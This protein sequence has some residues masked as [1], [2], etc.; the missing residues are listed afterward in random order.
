MP[1]AALCGAAATP[2]GVRCPA[3]FC[4]RRDFARMLHRNIECLHGLHEQ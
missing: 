4:H 2:A 1:N 3:R